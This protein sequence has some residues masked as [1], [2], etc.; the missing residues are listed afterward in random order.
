MRVRIMLI[1][2]IV[3]I[4]TLISIGVT[5]SGEQLKEKQKMNEKSIIIE[6][7][8][9][10]KDHQLFLENHYPSIQVVAVYTELFNGLAL[11]GDKRQLERMGSL[12]F[13]KNVHSVHKY[14]TT[15]SQFNQP[16]DKNAIFPF[17]LNNTT[18]T[19]KGVKVG[20]IDTGIDYNHPDLQT[21]YKSGY[22]VVDL[23]N[24][25]M[26]TKPKQGEP[27]LHGTHVAGIIA[28]NGNLKG[29]APDAELYGYRALGPGGSGTSVQV[30]AAMEQAIKD[31]VDIINLSLG[32]QVN[33]PD[34]PT[35]VA[36]NK[37]AELGVA[38]VIANGNAGPG[39]WTVGS[40]AT[41]NHALSVG[42]ASH[43]QQVP[44]LY[45][46]WENKRISIQEMAG[47]P[48]WLL[49]TFY[50]IMRANK[51]ANVKGKIALF[52]R[53]ETPFVEKVEQAQAAGAK[54]VIIANNEEGTL[55]G[56]VSTAKDAVQ[57]PVA[58]ISKQD[59]AWLEEYLQS[60]RLHLDTKY[61]NKASSIAPFSSRGPVT[62]NWNIKP[63]VVAP[64]TNI[65]S[66]VPG[67]Y[68]ALQG[69]SMAAP[70]VSGVIALIK[71]ARPEWTN[72]QI[73]GAIKTTALRME[74]NQKP[75]HPTIQGM[76]LIQPKE[77][78]ETRTIIDDPQITFGKVQGNSE[79]KN[80][81][82]T[83]ENRTNEEQTYYFD[84]PYKQRGISWNLPQAVTI[85][86]NEKK[87]LSIGARITSQ[88]LEEGV[89]QGWLTLKQSS[90]VHHIPYLFVNQ[91]ADN[92]KAMGFEFALEPLSNDTFSYRYY[93]TE[94]AT[95]VQV[96]LYDPDTLVFDR[97]LIENTDVAAGMNE[98]ELN[99]RK[100][101]NAGFYYAVV[102]VELNTGENASYET[103]I[104][105]P[106][107]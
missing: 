74:V 95:K 67:G 34:Y 5:S 35:S 21:N 88:Q 16:N 30:I 58:S 62:V 22:D 103:M 43:P 94:P 7:K 82:I 77:A 96:N 107:K 69:T 19:G 99:A 102:T 45:A 33:G 73:Y 36:V 15:T 28:A 14:E 92:P 29:V 66:T 64:G 106:P 87:Q 41:A 44:Y 70:H 90:T 49:D 91:N 101:G 10:P 46:R 2:M 83:I 24:D 4:M 61:E 57:I 85:P 11:K 32:N 68:Q 47:A 9:N 42:A 93:M 26:E 100:V 48:S 59:G 37:A 18:Y 50:P 75:L 31:D 81:Q 104:Y 53:D 51:G 13:V 78:I 105:V 65:V 86:P 25:P 1:S 39:G 38:V 72:Q 71:E 60:N 54:A 84:M 52:Q 17:D 12:E 3:V 20:V 79:V 8:G 76:G 98:G 56:D 80:E 97:Q 55:Q 89:H 23:D 63:D 40:P 27:T 6:V